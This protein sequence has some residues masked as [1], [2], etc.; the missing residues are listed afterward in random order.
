MKKKAIINPHNK[1]E[2]CFKWVVIA[3]ENVGMKNPQRVSNLRKFTNNY[4]RK[5]IPSIARLVSK[6]EGD[7]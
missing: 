1:D 3:A 7:N 4:E 5:L 6:E 2:E